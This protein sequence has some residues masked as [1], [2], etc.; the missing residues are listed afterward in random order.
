MARSIADDERTLTQSV[1]PTE[2]SPLLAANGNSA[3]YSGDN[4]ADAR[5][6]DPLLDPEADAGS[7][8]DDDDMDKPKITGVRIELIIPALAIGVRPFRPCCLGS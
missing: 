2:N 1:T 8:S 7:E 6:E 4:A 5:A 3:R